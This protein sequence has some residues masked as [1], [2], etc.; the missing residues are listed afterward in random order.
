MCLVKVVEWG[1]GKILTKRRGKWGGPLNYEGVP[2]GK[3]LDSFL[4]I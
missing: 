3:L 1:H 4:I 2:V